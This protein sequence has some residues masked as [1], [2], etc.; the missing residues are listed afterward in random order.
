MKK[1]IIALVAALTVCAG[2]AAGTTVYV[3]QPE[4]V[5]RNAIADV[6]E[7]FS[8]REEIAPVLNMLTEGSLEVSAKSNMDDA[9]VPAIL[10][11]LEAGG[12]IYFAENA[13]ML[14][15]FYAKA[16]DIEFRADA[17]MD[18]DLIYVTND[19]ILGGSWGIIRGEMAK[20]FSDSE[21][22]ESLG[23]P[24][25]AE[26]AILDVLEAYDDNRA[27]ELREDI[28]KYTEKY[29][30]IA[31][32]AVEDNAEYESESD[33]VKVGGERINAR[34]ITITVDAEAA[35]G[36]IEDIYDELKKDDKLRDTVIKYGDEFEEALK[37]A[38]VMSDDEDIADLYDEFIDE[39]GDSIDELDTDEEGEVVVEIVTPKLSSTLLKLSVKVK[40]DG[41]NETLLTLDVGE[42]GIKDSQLI[43]VNIG[44]YTTIEYE[45][46]ENTS[47]EYAS[48]MKV[49]SGDSSTTLFKLSIDKSEDEFKITVPEAEASVSGTWVDKGKTTTVTVNKIRVDDV[50]I[51]EFEITLILKEKDNMPN[52][53]SKKDVKNILD[54]TE[55]D[56]TEFA[57]NAEEI[58]GGYI[59]SQK[60]DVPEYGYDTQIGYNDGWNATYP[61]G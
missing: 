59:G 2:T 27:K 1:I 7:G 15:G 24:T 14:D 30:K 28:T 12:K 20:A 41:Y 5:A 57:E 18:E 10:S 40:E 22:I 60:D 46:E 43:S 4:V 8:E 55:D 37:T 56:V 47:K 58:F 49:K 32:K 11:D 44:G 9:D 6:I 42:E 29:M 61:I 36:I 51:D 16:D 52:P 33:E 35:A 21:L 26:D 45:I 34:V 53:V 25:E 19:D 23:M 31:I 48:S 13:L 39:I 3:N 38:K 54:I 50:T 17:Y